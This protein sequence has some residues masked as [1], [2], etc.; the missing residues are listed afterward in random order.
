MTDPLK[1]VHNQF[2]KYIKTFS[3]NSAW[4]DTSNSI[5]LD[6]S[7]YNP[8]VAKVI[9]QL[10]ESKMTLDKLGNI[11]KDVFMPPRV[12]RTYVPDIEYGIPFLQGSHVVHFKPADIK[13]VSKTTQ[14]YIDK[15]IIRAGWILVTRSGTTG[16][17][18]MALNS[19]DGW[20]ASE[21]IFRIVPDEEKCSATYLYAF[22]SSD[23]GQ[24]QLN[25]HIYGAV[26]DELTP[27]HIR[28]I[29]VPIPKTKQQLEKVKKIDSTV[30][31]A[32]QLKEEAAKLD[33]KAI[34]SVA[35]FVDD[36]ATEAQI[37]PLKPRII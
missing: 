13:Y 34:D 1:T 25:S 11:T 3:L 14:K 33:D 30:R 31:K 9:E 12:K 17:A 4:L 27:E 35:M 8:A 21:H 23:L 32:F 26:V 10:E 29:L 6:A 37:K 24:I 15:L 28:N 36:S 7:H 16:R 22:L 20:A 18:T 5:R 19:W 2:K